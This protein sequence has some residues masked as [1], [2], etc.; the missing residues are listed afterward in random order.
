MKEF[1]NYENRKIQ[2][3]MTENSLNMSVTKKHETVLIY[4]LEINRFSD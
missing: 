4:L 2:S 1:Y 3:K